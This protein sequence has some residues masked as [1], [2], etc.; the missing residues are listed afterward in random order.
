MVIEVLLFHEKLFQL[1]QKL[2]VLYIQKFQVHFHKIV[3]DFQ[4]KNKFLEMFQNVVQGNHL[5]PIHLLIIIVKIIVIV[6][7]IIVIIKLPLRVYSMITYPFASIL[8]CS[9]NIWR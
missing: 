1:N 5:H 2:V 8:L 9:N 3:I 4:L 6:V 7:V